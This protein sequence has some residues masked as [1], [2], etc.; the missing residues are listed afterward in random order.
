MLVEQLVEALAE[1]GLDPSH[2]E[3]E[4]TETCAMKD[5]DKSIDILNSIKKLGVRV[6]IDDFG[7]GYSS[8]SYLKKFPVNTL[9][10]D[11]AFVRDIPDDT[12]DMAI[13][14]A[15]IQMASNLDVTVVAEGVETKEQRDFLAGKGCAMAQGY[16]FSRPLP[17][18]DYML[19]L[20]AY[21]QGS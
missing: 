17:I 5:T 18:D 21:G 2:L 15:I 4:V 20:A 13:T 10:V 7:T 14:T 1:T 19:W 12:D 6:S 16:Y 8:L 3:L 9:K 11:R